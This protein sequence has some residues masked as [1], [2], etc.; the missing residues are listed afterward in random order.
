METI[1]HN[2][3]SLTIIAEISEN[4]FA[5]CKAAPCH[6]VFKALD[7]MFYR[8]VKTNLDGYIEVSRIEKEDAPILYARL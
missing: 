8:V 7:G 1:L 6:R 3:E 5:P 4:T 2:G